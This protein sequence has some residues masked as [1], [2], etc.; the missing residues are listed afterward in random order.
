MDACKRLCTIDL[1]LAY[2]TDMVKQACICIGGA[3]CVCML[4]LRATATC[5]VTRSSIMYMRTNTTACK[6]C[7][8]AHHCSTVWHG[9]DWELQHGPWPCV[10]RPG[11]TGKLMHQHQGTHR[12]PERD[13]LC[14]V[15]LSHS[16]RHGETLLSMVCTLV[17][18]GCINSQQVVAPYPNRA[19]CIPQ[20]L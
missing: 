2:H 17:Q 11:S 9:S 10:L 19:K 8:C 14:T 15:T 3:P 16:M 20:M 7:N 13:G 1:M 12:M 6:Q 18:D 5:A 4:Q